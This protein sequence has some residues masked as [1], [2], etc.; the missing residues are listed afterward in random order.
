MSWA[1]LRYTPPSS[2]RGNVLTFS[3]KTGT[4]IRKRP[5][6]LKQTVTIGTLVFDIRLF[7]G[8]W[9]KEKVCAPWILVKKVIIKRR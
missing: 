4:T 8:A 3:P 6:V 5:D 1:R 9:K 2:S 7:T